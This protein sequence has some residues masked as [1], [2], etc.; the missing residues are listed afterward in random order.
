MIP[1]LLE[2][3]SYNGFFKISNGMV[4]LKKDIYSNIYPT[5]SQ[6]GHTYGLPTMHNIQSPTAIPPFRPIIS[7]LNTFNYQ[8]EK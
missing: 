2:K 6:P 8:L 7:S 3:A 4:K 5:G 1:P